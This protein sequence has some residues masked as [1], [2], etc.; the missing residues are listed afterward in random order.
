[1]LCTNHYIC[2]MKRTFIWTLAGIIAISFIGLF[3]IQAVIIKRL[4]EDTQDKFN[5]IVKSCLSRV[6]NNIEQNELIR[7]LS[8]DVPDFFAEN[9]SSAVISQ[10]KIDFKI[11]SDDGLSSI[12]G[13]YQQS[14][15]S[16]TSPTIQPL[17]GN[18]HDISS[19]NKM[20]Q[21]KQARLMEQK[22]IAYAKSMERILQAEAKP[23][24]ERLDTNFL[25]RSIE[26]E[27][28]NNSINLP[29]YV[30]IYSHNQGEVFRS[31]DYKIS[32][33]SA[34]IR[35][36]LFPNDQ[37][38]KANYLWVYFPTKKQYIFKSMRLVTPTFVFILIL[39]LTF[40]ITM[41][42]IFKQK[43]LSEIKNDFINNM[44]HEFKTPISSI[45]LASQMLKDPGITKT[46][47]SLSHISAVINDESKRLSF[48]VEKILQMAIFDKDKSRLKLT[49]LDASELINS[50]IANF[51]LKV[52]NKQGQIVFD[53]QAKDTMVLA[54]EVHFTNV[55]YNLLDNALKYTVNTPLLKVKTW[56]EKQKL[57]ISVKDNG[58]GIKREDLKRIF[59]RFYRVPTGNL[60][61]VKGFGLGLAYV[62]KII[63]DHNGLI[64]V[65][66]EIN[67]GT[68]FIICLP[69][70]TNKNGRKN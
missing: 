4:A 59:E 18:N 47:R 39:V 58:I 68:E 12:H 67:N 40:V 17:K 5:Q 44:T 45:S 51:S 3:S 62:K 21:E 70:N 42:I 23:V 10:G 29:F 34:L 28:L 48:Q 69:L 60:H 65:E 46:P 22:R 1:M 8:P 20:I 55:I 7:P 36:Q 63:E 24:I 38:P 25:M 54:D 2:F 56:N 43:R 35:R 33:K 49:E 52:T 6:I 50:V 9:E 14:I 41:Y 57:H 53:N 61:N 27:L 37:N 66:S 13:S 26:Q 32:D 15:V 30:S 16:A 64:K 31:G 11:Q 19:R